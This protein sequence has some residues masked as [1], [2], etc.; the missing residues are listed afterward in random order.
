MSPA[1]RRSQAL[2]DEVLHAN[3]VR[4]IRRNA[5][6][7]CLADSKYD[8]YRRANENTNG[9]IRPYFP[10]MLCYDK[11]SHLAVRIAQDSISHHPLLHN[12]Y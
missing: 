6:N 8:G 4:L 7:M 2:S 10:K 1:A 5:V 9:L 11:S 12:K 3:A